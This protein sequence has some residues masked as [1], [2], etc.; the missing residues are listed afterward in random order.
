MLLV[1]WPL[2]STSP[3][4]AAPALIDEAAKKALAVKSWLL[5]ERLTNTSVT[6][7]PAARWIGFGAKPKFQTVIVTGGAGCAAAGLTPRVER[8]AAAARREKDILVSFRA[9]A[10]RRL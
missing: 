6:G 9:P 5:P 7:R 2:S 8:A 1:S 3:P 4:G 10:R